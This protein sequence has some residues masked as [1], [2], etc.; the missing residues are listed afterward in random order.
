MLYIY[1][2]NQIRDHGT[3]SGLEHQRAVLANYIGQA[4]CFLCT[5]VPCPPEDGEHELCK[6][7]RDINWIPLTFFLYRKRVYAHSPLLNTLVIFHIMIKK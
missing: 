2:L 4:P 7:R 6:K 1:A 5:D 3:W